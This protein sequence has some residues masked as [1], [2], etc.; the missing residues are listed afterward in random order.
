MDMG[1][2]TNIG[3]GFTAFFRRFTLMHFNIGMGPFFLWKG[4]DTFRGFGHPVWCGVAGN[5]GCCQG[6]HK[7]GSLSESVG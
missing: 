4:E 1:I 2:K 5:L 7:V 3:A 6:G